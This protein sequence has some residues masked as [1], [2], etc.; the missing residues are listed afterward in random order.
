MEVKEIVNILTEMQKWR[1]A[2]EP[3]AYEQR[4]MPFTPAEYGEALDAA[5]ELLK[6]EL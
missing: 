5:I 1:R 3:Y 6:E 4:S 2:E